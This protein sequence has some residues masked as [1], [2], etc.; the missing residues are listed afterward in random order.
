MPIFSD[1]TDGVIVAVVAAL[2]LGFGTYCVR[3]LRTLRKLTLWAANQMA[4]D[5]NGSWRS[6]IDKRLTAIERA[7]PGVTP[8]PEGRSEPPVTK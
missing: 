3:T 2:V 6:T 1:I 8:K 5:G 7:L 4:N